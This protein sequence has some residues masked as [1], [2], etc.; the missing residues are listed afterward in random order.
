MGW[1][2]YTYNN[3]VRIRSVARFVL[4]IICLPLYVCFVLHVCEYARTRFTIFVSF[5]V[6]YFGF[7]MFYW[8][9]INFICFSLCQFSFSFSHFLQHHKFR[10]LC[11]GCFIVLC[12]CVCFFALFLFDFGTEKEFT[13]FFGV[14]L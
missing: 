11:H 10:L 8:N 12:L 3:P 5:G 14:Q 2:C 9:S 6:I 1:C 4:Q 13:Y 7:S